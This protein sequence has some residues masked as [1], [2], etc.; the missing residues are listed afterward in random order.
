MSE[1]KIIGEGAPPS[2][3]LN[4]E[5]RR[6][7]LADP[8]LILSDREV[9]RALIGA[10]ESEVGGNVIDIRGR[11]MKAMEDRLNRLEA[12]H[13]TVISNAYENQS[14]QAMIQR[15]VL[16]LMEPVDFPSFLESL[17]G[18][19]APTLRIDTLRLVFESAQDV[20]QGLEWL[21]IVPEGGIEEI[22]SAGRRAPRGDDIVLRPVSSATRPIHGS[23]N[24]TIRSEALLPMNLGTGRAPALLIMGSSDALRFDAAQGT[25]LLRFFAQ[26][27]RLALL[28][29]LRE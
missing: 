6:Q 4:D 22:L 27:F 19:V 15:A 3:A 13:Q 20:P 26:A 1:D 8:E 21:H 25:D 9:M 17:E 7:L 24:G 10:H 11:A 29:W 23:D 14:G 2:P 12:A 28:G 5:L 18:T 16:A